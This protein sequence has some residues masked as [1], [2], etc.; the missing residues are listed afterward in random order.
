MD[1]L[2]E[3]FKKP[4]VWIVLAGVVAIYF[5]RGRLAGLG[6]Q[7]G[8]IPQPQ[9]SGG[10][11]GGGAGYGATASLSPQDQLAYNQ[12]QQQSQLGYQQ[13]QLALAAQQ[14]QN[15]YEGQLQ[16]LQ[17][18]QYGNQVGYQKA[19][20]QLEQQYQSSLLP[21]AVGLGQEQY[22]T[23]TQAQRQ[24]TNYYKAI[25]GAQVSCP[26]TA[27]M[28]I[29]PTTGQAYCR[30]KTS[31]S[32]LGLPIGGLFRVGQGVVQGAQAYAPTA[33]YNLAQ[34]GTQYVTQQYLTSPVRPG[35]GGMPAR[36]GQTGG[37]GPS[38]GVLPSALFN[39]S[40]FAGPQGIPGYT[41]GI[42]GPIQ[43]PQQAYSYGGQQSSQPI[44]WD[45]TALYGGR[46]LQTGG[47]QV[48]GGQAVYAP[49]QRQGAPSPYG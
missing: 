10:G 16:N 26:G 1:K 49:S 2:K 25:A 43:G 21:S 45:Q 13:A 37:Q 9:P 41:T 28:R 22:A 40:G 14:Q 32:I 24:Q 33:G 30:Q 5:L 27:S 47:T 17:L 38:Y 3:L 29:D 11:G 42:A 39:P 6:Q 8:A 18:Q 36:T 34:A 35:G 46:S 48:S 23:A 20:L 31:G 12:Q 7:Q 4:W 19:G 15:T 44:S